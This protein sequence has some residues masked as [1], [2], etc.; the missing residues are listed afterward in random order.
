MVTIK[1]K[2]CKRKGT[3]VYP[4]GKGSNAKRFLK[5]KKGCKFA[6]KEKKPRL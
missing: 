5:H 3:K 6:P 4:F 1:C 2:N